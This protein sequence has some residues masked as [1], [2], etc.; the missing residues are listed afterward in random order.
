M[1]VE[2]GY[3]FNELGPWTVLLSPQTQICG[4]LVR[5]YH[6]LAVVTLPDGIDKI[7]MYWFAGSNIQKA[8]IPASVK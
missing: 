8:I 5:D 1:Y 2:E 7:G 4:K 6:S 3:Q